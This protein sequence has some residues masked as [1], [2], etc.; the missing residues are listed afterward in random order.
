MRSLNVAL[1]ARSYPIHIGTGLLARPDLVLPHLKAPLVA[2][3]SNETVAPVYLAGFSAALR[4][5][6]VR[7]TEIIL[8]DGEEYKTWQTLNRIFD[9]LLE[10]RCER[11]TTARAHDARCPEHG[12][13]STR[14]C[15]ALQSAEG[16][17]RHRRS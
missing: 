3:V 9:A 13:A 1:D 6:G 4:D 11:A 17:T 10:N 8:P 7:V 12:R 2:I 5:R 14:L 15:A 16:A